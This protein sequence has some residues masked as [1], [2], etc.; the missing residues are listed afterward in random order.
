MPK[1]VT[2]YSLHSILIAGCFLDTNNW[3]EGSLKIAKIVLVA[4]L[5]I[6]A[7]LALLSGLEI[8][9]FPTT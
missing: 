6:V 8:G 9:E 4:V 1:G 2:R 7:A 5:I 3:G